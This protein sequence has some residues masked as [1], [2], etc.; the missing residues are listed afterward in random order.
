MSGDAVGH[1]Q[2]FLL[3]SPADLQCARAATAAFNQFY[4][5]WEELSQV[6]TELLRRGEHPGAWYT[7]GPFLRAVQKPGWDVVTVLKQAPFE[8]YQESEALRQEV[9]L[10]EWAKRLDRALE[11]W[12]ESEP[13]WSG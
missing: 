5:G 12:E 7:K 4:D 3:K 6:N 9:T 13:L 8:V 2:K 1:I 11:R 10:Q